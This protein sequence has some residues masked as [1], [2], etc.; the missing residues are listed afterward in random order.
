MTLTDL[1]LAQIP[2]KAQ[3]PI[4]GS[5]LLKIHARGRGDSLHALGADAEGT[6]SARVLQG[7]MRASLAELAGVDLRGL[8]LTLTGSSREVAVRCAAAEFEI[9]SGVMRSTR[10]FIDSEP[11]FISGEGSV[12]LDPETVELRLHGEPKRL[13]I[14]R[15]KAPVLVQGTL[16]QPKLSIDMADPGLRVVDPGT[17]Q[18]A[19]CGALQLR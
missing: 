5:L 4:E 19:D 7:T 14:M 6:L 2:H 1:Q 10:F 13:R 18:N 15:I 16:L 8:G 3:P 11:V 9:H 12:L 17:R